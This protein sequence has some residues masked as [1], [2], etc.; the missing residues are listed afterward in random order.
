M[1]QN[2]VLIAI[3]VAFSVIMLVLIGQKLKVAYPIF[4]VIAGLIISL[5]PGMPAF[6]IDPDIVFLIFLPP[7]LFEAAWFT[8]WKDFWKHG[9]KFRGWPLGWYFL[10]RW[11]WLMFPHR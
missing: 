2:Y 4:L 7:I 8:S 10:H 5:I 3:A 9:S 1:I 11:L 6:Q